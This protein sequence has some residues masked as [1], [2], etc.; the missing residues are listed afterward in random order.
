MNKKYYVYVAGPYTIGDVALNVAN[1]LGCADRL[2]YNGFVPFVPHLTHLWH[3]VFP[4]KYTYWTN[5]DL[6]W[7]K[8]CDCLLRLPGESKGADAEVKFA[9]GIFKPVFYSIPDLI[10]WRKDRLWI[11]IPTEKIQ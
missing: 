5:Y 2:I 3:L 9:E 8:K 4:H 7:L 1:A 6:E 10:Q 11:E